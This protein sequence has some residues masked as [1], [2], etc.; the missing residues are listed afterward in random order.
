MKIRTIR[1]MSDIKRIVS[2]FIRVFSDEPYKEK[3]TRK[4][5]EI[6][7][8]E[9]YRNGKGFCFCAEED[10]RMAGFIFSQKETWHDGVH[11]FIEDT[12]V[13]KAFRGKGIGTM[14]V[15]KLE[16]TAKKKGIT[17]IDFMVDPK[18]KAA[19]FWK[20][21]GYKPNGYIEMMKRL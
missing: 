3:W 11:L 13:E 16:K 8:Y 18:S 15:S 17:S 9:A 21:C 1:G 6:R 4:F 20:K 7:M 12:G 5:A 2:V 10:G 14:L 19:K